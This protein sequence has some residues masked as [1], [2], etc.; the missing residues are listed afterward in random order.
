MKGENEITEQLLKHLNKGGQLHVV[1]A[2][3]K[4]K[5]IIRFT[6]TSYYTTEDDI[7]RDWRIIKETADQVLKRREEKT[8]FERFQSSLLLSNVPQTPKFVN[9]SF[10]AFFPD[11]DVMFNI[12]KE[13]NN[14]D[15]TQSHMPLTPRGKTKLFLNE[16]QKQLSFEHSNTL[17]YGTSLNKKSNYR[18]FK[19]HKMYMMSKLHQQSSLDSKIEHIFDEQ[20]YLQQTNGDDDDKNSQNVVNAHKYIK[21]TSNSHLNKDSFEEEAAN[22]QLEEELSLDQLIIEN[23]KNYY[24]KNQMNSI[25]HMATSDADA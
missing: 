7:R 16:P 8:K 2:S 1:P 19:A 21:K 9:A 11:P 23:Q 12:I 14:R 17:S 22:G 25:K 10:A 13:L 15:Y 18:N 3:I 6:V 5:Y 20:E 4:G 24:Q